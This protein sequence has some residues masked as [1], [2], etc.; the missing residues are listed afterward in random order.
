MLYNR[1]NPIGSQEPT[2]TITD[3]KLYVP[4]V[5][6]SAQDYVKLL[7]QLKS[8]FKRTSNWNKYYPKVT[9]EQ[10]NRY[11]YYLINPSFQGV[12]TLFFII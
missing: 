6:L 3:Q 2:F 8:G 5:T 4:V 9:I 7:Q 12:N 1:Y 11:L 10:Q